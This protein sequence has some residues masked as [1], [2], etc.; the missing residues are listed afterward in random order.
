MRELLSPDTCVQQRKLCLCLLL[1]CYSELVRQ[2]GK[3]RAESSIVCPGKGQLLIISHYGC[4]DV[5][6]AVIYHQTASLK[7]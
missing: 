4:L 1:P 7:M 3:N 6:V 5:T 2:K